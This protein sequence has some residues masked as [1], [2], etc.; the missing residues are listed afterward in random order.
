MWPS[1]RFLLL[2]H[3][4]HT[5]T[6]HNTPLWTVSHMREIQ[7]NMVLYKPPPYPYSLTQTFTRNYRIIY[8]LHALS[9]TLSSEACQVAFESMS[10]PSAIEFRWKRWEHSIITLQVQICESLSVKTSLSR[11]TFKPW[12]NVLSMLSP[13]GVIW[14]C[15]STPF[16]SDDYSLAFM[17]Y[18][19]NYTAW[20]FH[21]RLMIYL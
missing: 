7:K 20:Y 8:N 9:A 18:C 2:Y 16:S 10:A 13:E 1:N 3:T 5:N 12:G 4:N 6:C 21:G 14:S 11:L 15:P 17:A 19:H